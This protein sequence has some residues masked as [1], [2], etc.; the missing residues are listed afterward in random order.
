MALLSSILSSSKKLKHVTIEQL[1][2]I[3]ETWKLIRRGLQ[4]NPS[5]THLSF[6]FCLPQRDIPSLIVSHIQ[7]S[8][9]S[10][11]QH[12]RYLDLSYAEIPALTI[13]QPAV[14]SPASLAQMLCSSLLRDF[15]LSHHAPSCGCRVLC[16]L[17][18]KLVVGAT[19]VD[20]LE[21]SCAMGHVSIPFIKPSFAPFDLYILAK[22]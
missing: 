1:M 7:S 8:N 5:I 2:I 20:A 21:G 10:S 3:S 15:R 16:M 12:V 4:A 19:P 22:T 6:H 14:S 13:S 9:K 18:N 17:I 11:H